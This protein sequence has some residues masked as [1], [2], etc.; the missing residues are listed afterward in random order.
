[1]YLD[2]FLSTVSKTLPIDVS[3]RKCESTFKEQIAG[4]MGAYLDTNTTVRCLSVTG[5]KVRCP[6][7]DLKAS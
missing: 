4:H 2:V 3:S 7:R 5:T 1:M 6:R